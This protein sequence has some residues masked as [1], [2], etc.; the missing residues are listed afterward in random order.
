MM[1]IRRVEYPTRYDYISTIIFRFAVSY[2]FYYHHGIGQIT[3]YGLNI[4]LSQVMALYFCPFFQG[5]KLQPSFGRFRLIVD[6]PRD[7]WVTEVAERV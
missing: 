5:Q 1:R 7:P 2:T 3:E 6:A 4:S